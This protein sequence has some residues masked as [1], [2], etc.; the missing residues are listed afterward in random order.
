MTETPH[1][2]LIAFDADDTLWHNEYLYT[3]AKEQ[4][5]LLLASFG[6]PEEVRQQLD[7]VEEQ[8]V[9]H[10]GYGIKSFTLSMV[11][12]AMSI[13]QGCVAADALQSILHLGKQMLSAELPFLDNAEAT[14]VVLSQQYP[15]MMIT[16]GD[17][18]E[19]Q[20][21]IERSGLAKYF[22]YIEIVASKTPTTYQRLFTQHGI[23]PGAAL[24]VG[25]SLR[26]DIIPVLEIGG[27]AVYIHYESTW[28]HEHVDEATRARYQYLEIEH[29]GE[30]PELVAKLNGKANF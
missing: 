15:L 13:S 10:Y 24:M 25:N 9:L 29:L 5:C 6:G 7:I 28:S 27:Q 4:F 26:S 1:I 17:T 16:K 23:D 19:Q 20:R 30:L 12:T 18:F 21:K 22:R 2:S 3:Q 14:L 8:N 11:E